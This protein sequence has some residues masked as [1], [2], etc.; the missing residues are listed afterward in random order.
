MFDLT[1]GFLTEIIQEPMLWLFFIFFFLFIIV[2]YRV[3][4]MLTR[5]LI[6]AAISGFFPIFANFILGMPIPVTLENIFWFAITGTEIYF[7]YHILV[8]FGKIAEFFN[9]LFSRG[10]EKKVEKVIIVEKSKDKDEKEK[11]SG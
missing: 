6:I 3:V 10:K 5:A 1:G 11:G 8:G 2:A 4:K 9:K 7:V